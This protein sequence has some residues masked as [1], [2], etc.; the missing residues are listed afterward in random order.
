MHTSKT[1]LASVVPEIQNSLYHVHDVNTIKL[2][3]RKTALQLFIVP[4]CSIVNIQR[5]N[6]IRSRYITSILIECT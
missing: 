4:V 1:C 2:R 6:M 3:D 5:M